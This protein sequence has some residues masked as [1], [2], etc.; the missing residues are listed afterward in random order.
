M[1][2]IAFRSGLRDL[3]WVS[4][5]RPGRVLSFLPPTG[6]VSVGKVRCAQ[7]RTVTVTEVRSG[8]VT[9]PKSR[10]MRAKEQYLGLLGGLFVSFVCCCSAL[11]GTRQNNAMESRRSGRLLGGPSEG[12]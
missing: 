1:L 5:L 6:I 7:V 2:P 11:T 4:I 9:R 12:P 10:I 3:C 8:F